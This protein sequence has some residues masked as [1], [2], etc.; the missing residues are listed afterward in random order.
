[1]EYQDKTLKCKECGKDFT[2]TSGEQSFYAKKG[3]ENE[4]ARCYDCRST[5][6]K[7]RDFG[8]R[9]R[10]LFEVVCYQCGNKTS[11]PFQPRYQKPV[12]CRECFEKL[13]TKEAVSA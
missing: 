8:R 4:P 10:E 2:F 6:R 11:V 3:F 9:T 1:M 12:Y 13:N 5:R 7:E